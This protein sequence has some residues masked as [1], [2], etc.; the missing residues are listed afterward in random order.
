M[1]K[2]SG[3]PK[4]KAPAEVTGRPAPATEMP[5]GAKSGEAKFAESRGAIVMAYAVAILFSLLP[6][7]GIIPK[8][9]ASYLGFP[10]NDIQNAYR[11]F[12]SFACEELFRGYLPVWNPYIFCGTPFLANT[13][14]TIYYPPNLL[15]WLSLPQ[16]LALNVATLLHLAL[17]AGGMTY[18][19]RCRGLSPTASAFAGSVGGLGAIMIP[20]IFAGHFTMVCTLAWVPLVLARQWLLLRE[21]SF[22]NSTMLGLVFGA[23]LLG[24]HYQIGYYAVLFCFLTLLVMLANQDAENRRNWML[25]QLRCHTVAMAVAIGLAA[26]EMVPVADS[27]RFSAR[28]AEKTAEWF[29]GFSML[30]KAYLGFVVPRI[31]ME[32]SAA[33]GPWYWWEQ[34]IYL[35]MIP[36][37]LA[38]GRMAGLARHGRFS[39]PAAALLFSIIMA[40]VGLAPNADVVLRWVPGWA[41]FRGHGRILLF[42]MIYGILL[43]AEQVDAIRRDGRRAVWGST[44]AA[45]FL[46]AIVWATSR[47]IPEG[48]APKPSSTDRLSLLPFGESVPL[49][50][51]WAR[52]TATIALGAFAVVSALRWKHAVCLLLAL[53]AIDLVLHAWIPAQFIT[54]A[55]NSYAPKLFW[56]FA[57]DNQSEGR[58]QSYASYL[59]SEPVSQDVSVVGGNDISL[60]RYI[61]TA[62]AAMSG[63]P[64]DVVQFDF[65]PP[66][67]HPLL[68]AA[69]LR[70]AAIPNNSGTTASRELEFVI[71]HGR[72]SMFRRKSA[73]P[74]AYVIPQATFIGESEAAVY[75]Q[76]T[77]STVNFQRTVLLCDDSMAGKS[78]GTA[79]DPVPAS[80]AYQGNSLV[81]IRVPRD[82]AGWLVLA[83]SYYPHWT[84]TINGAPTRVYRA[85]GAF[86]AIKVAGG[87]EVVFHYQIRWQVAGII[88]SLVTVGFLL[89]H[90]LGITKR[91]LPSA[92][93]KSNT[94]GSA[95]P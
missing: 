23:L 66:R 60:S 78:E 1:R 86:R 68:D 75:D 90:A 91:I 41:V 37:A 88:I 76:L 40:S 87:E 15:L 32:I 92:F 85:N 19:A 2:K 69:N 27:L 46:C 18:L 70:F 62:F 54:P 39:W 79:G 28:S 67:R 21:P 63:K 35:G 3:N 11:H 22:R 43:A 53:S 94:L 45:A 14:S 24:G 59:S 65:T 48:L 56:K 34:P 61:N 16:P 95:S 30:P 4:D 58:I 72:Y 57:R 52:Y 25:T 6:Y 8:L 81:H 77:T 5:L 44:L 73:L 10:H 36:L 20:R 47:F 38:L 51:T 12:V 83:D 17:F 50:W 84:A 26:V 7:A 13:N 33:A 93:A 49:A 31:R 64:K 55:A 9:A 42:G 80:V 82:V 89:A 74:R 29:T 71:N